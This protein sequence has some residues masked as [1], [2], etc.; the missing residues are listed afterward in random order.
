M[1]AFC[2]MLSFT[3]ILMGITWWYAAP[4]ANL[5]TQWPRQLGR[6]VAYCAVMIVFGAQLTHIEYD[7]PPT[8][9]NVYVL[10][11]LIVQGGAVTVLG[12]YRFYAVKR[13]LQTAGEN[14]RR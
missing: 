12:C 11:F 8:T 13:R 14:Q 10:L 3:P 6:I 2:Q 7:E 4:L 5:R 1:R 9:A